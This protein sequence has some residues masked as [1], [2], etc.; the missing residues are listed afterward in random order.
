M[1]KSILIANRGEIAS[2]VMRTARRLA[3][4]CIAVYS[5]ADRQ[6]GHVAEADEAYRIGPAPATESYLRI[7]AIIAA[8]VSA[9][10]D[11]IHPGYGF[12]SEK[13]EFADACAAAGITFI[14]PPA[15]AMRAMGLKDA[16]KLLMQKAGVPV[17]PG[18]HGG[19]GDPRF[20]AE[21][22][23]EIGYPILVKATAGGG[24]KG[25]RRVD[26][27][28][29]LAA[30]LETASREAAASFGDGRILIE[31]FLPK[32]RHIEIQIFADN[33]GN[34][35]SLFE[36]DCSLQRRHQ[37]II[38][39][40]PAP[41]VS[42]EMR[43]AMGDAAVKAARAVEY[44]GAGTVEFI[45]DISNGLQ[46]NGF[47]FLEMNTRLQ[48]EHPVT[49]AI[50]DL[51]LV[52]WQLRVAAGEPLP[53]RQDQL[54][55]TG[56]AFEARIYAEDPQRQFLPSTGRL[57]HLYFPRGTRVDSGVREGDEI[58]PN[59]D[60]LIAK[61]IVHGPDRPAA[62]AKLAAALGECRAVGCATNI[63]FLKAL[64]G[65]PSV[66]AGLVDTGLV[67]REVANLAPATKPC[68]DLVAIAAIASLA[69]LE[70]PADANPWS[71]LLGWRAWGEN[72][73]Y[74]C[75]VAHD[76]K[77]E[78]HVSP[79]GGRAF[80]VEWPGVTSMCTLVSN[81][82]EPLRIEI[83]NRTIGATVVTGSHQI[84][85]F[86]NGQNAMFTRP[87]VAAAGQAQQP[88]SDLIVSPLSGLVKAVSC[89]PGGQVAKGCGL[90]VIEAMKLEHTIVAGQDGTVAQVHVKAGDQVSEG[91][92]LLRFANNPAQRG[93]T[94]A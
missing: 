7:D 19:G 65:H 73:C 25:M 51:D 32:A 60:P 20:L 58:T 28:R 70:A 45:A 2:R 5:D 12:L 11:A 71:T 16:A 44:R 85:V 29:G 26:D 78:G 52:E 36:R 22:A 3:I 14:G 94:N 34:A 80:K 49:E 79:L 89:A 74:F 48:V 21:K 35:V 6:A 72:R 17:V 1:F 37:K 77:I 88:T 81:H 53:L 30:A 54:A 27:P 86:A 87:V 62:L 13:A 18:Y 31:K 61:L 43:R 57:S 50:T 63:A 82:G 69:L 40:A 67:E 91:T 76:Q 83:G 47:Y 56:H 59:Y 15:A 33:H 68:D 84:D 90:V 42:P 46:A 4:R 23:R 41:G 66:V 39:E 93:A 24:G 8:A 92:E 9:K 55:I 64:S 75:L 38:E 10:A